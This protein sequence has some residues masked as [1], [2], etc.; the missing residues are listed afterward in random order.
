MLAWDHELFVNL[1]HVHGRELA[2]P[3]PGYATHGE[4]GMLSQLVDWGAVMTVRPFVGRTQLCRLDKQG[5]CK[6][7]QGSI[8]AKGEVFEF[9]GLFEDE[10]TG[11]EARLRWQ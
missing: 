9:A 11:D 2:M 7:L 1:R 6:Y 3:M 4:E 10:L 5:A 8:P